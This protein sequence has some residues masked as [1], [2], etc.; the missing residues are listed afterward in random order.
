MMTM[1]M[2]DL[3][4]EAAAEVRRLE[5]ARAVIRDGDTSTLAR[6]EGDAAW[7]AMPRRGRLRRTLG[8]R[9]CLVWRAAFEDACGRVIES[10]L[11]PVLVDS[12]WEVFEPVIRARVE[13]E[14]NDWAADVVRIVDAFA[15]ARLARG[16]R[17]G[18]H[19]P[20]PSVGSQPGLFD[21]RAERSVRSR[22]AAAADSE[23]DALDR[24]RTI[25]AGRA[26]ARVPAR[27]LLILVP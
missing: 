6:L 21:R 5:R 15:S 24:L 26:I 13:A 18:L 9:V 4:A 12:G 23:R 20:L 2:M 1:Q 3:R 14:C 19:Q 8:R 16:R 11:V 17:L 7:I 25:A 10:R 27:L 22:D